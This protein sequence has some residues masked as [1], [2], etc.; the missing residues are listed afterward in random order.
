MKDFLRKFNSKI[1]E[2]N[3]YWLTAFAKA[4]E[5]GDVPFFISRDFVQ[6]LQ[7]E[8]GVFPKNFELLLDAVDKVKQDKDLC[9]F[10]KVLYHLIGLRVERKLIFNQ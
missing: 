5:D 8:Y 2:N 10:A 9:F 3:E 1:D 7:N 4:K 6:K